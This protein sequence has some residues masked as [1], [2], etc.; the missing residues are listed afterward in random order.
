MCHVPV[1]LY[2]ASA[3]AGIEG[4]KWLSA[5]LREC[6]YGNIRDASDAVQR[7]GLQLG[8]ASR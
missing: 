6:S 1:M 2:Y 8:T 3:A 7:E 5:A 4:V